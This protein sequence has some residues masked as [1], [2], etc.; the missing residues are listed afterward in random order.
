MS[1]VSCFTAVSAPCWQTRQTLGR[2][3]TGLRGGGT[4]AMTPSG[5]RE[6]HGQGIRGRVLLAEPVQGGKRKGIAVVST[7]VKIVLTMV[8]NCFYCGQKLFRRWSK[9]VSSVGK[10]WFDCGQKLFRL[11][12][13]T[14][15]TVVKSRFDC[16]QKPF[17]LWSEGPGPVGLRAINPSPVRQGAFERVHRGPDVVHAHRG[18]RPHARPDVNPSMCRHG[19]TDCRPVPADTLGSR[20]ASVAVRPA[21]SCGVGRVAPSRE[22]APRAPAIRPY[23]APRRRGSFAIR[24]FGDSGP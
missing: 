6:R 16:G 11:W 14:V 9:T 4:G 3:G 18:T 19:V 22:A 7:V 23:C 10:N 13:K 12:S 17:R 21:E 24:R 8:K 5:A 20:P 15:S 1:A 2:L